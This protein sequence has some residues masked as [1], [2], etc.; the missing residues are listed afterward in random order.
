MTF[1]DPKEKKQTKRKATGNGLTLV[2]IWFGNPLLTGGPL[3]NS[4]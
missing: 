2:G 3:E 4:P 1:L